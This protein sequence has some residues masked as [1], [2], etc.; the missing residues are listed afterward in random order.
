MPN[1]V[2][3][4]TKILINVSRAFFSSTFLT[5]WHCLHWWVVYSTFVKIALLQINKMQTSHQIYWHYFKDTIQCSQFNSLWS[6]YSQVM[7]IFQ[8]HICYDLTLFALASSI[9]QDCVTVDNQNARPTK[10]I[11]TTSKTQWHALS[12]SLWSAYSSLG[13]FSSTILSTWH[14]LHWRVVY[15]TLVKIALQQMI[16]VQMSH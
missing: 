12:N 9:Q 15:C 10:Y 3:F 14:Y 7:N 11:E 13:F 8:F 16:K 4:N 5:T 2:S 6:T 1:N